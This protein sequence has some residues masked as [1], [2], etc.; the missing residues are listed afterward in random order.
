MRFGGG[1]FGS[2]GFEFVAKTVDETIDD[3]DV[4]SDDAELFFNMNANSVYQFFMFLFVNGHGIPD[5]QWA[6]VGPAGAT[7]KIGFGG[8]SST[9]DIANRALG[10]SSGNITMNIANATMYLSGIITTGAT[11]GLLNFQ[12]AQ[13]LASVGNDTTVQRD[14]SIQFRRLQDA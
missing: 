3:D 9:G 5:F 10:V 7:G 4:L 6:F 11:P 1:G 14:S 13:F 2:S 12:W 8:W